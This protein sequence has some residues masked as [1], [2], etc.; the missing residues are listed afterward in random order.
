MSFLCFFLC[1]SYDVIDIRHH[2]RKAC[3]AF[4]FF[5]LFFF[6]IHINVTE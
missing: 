5:L 1:A 6:I 3:E 4:S 2:G